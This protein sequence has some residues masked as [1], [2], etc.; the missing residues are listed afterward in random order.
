MLFLC[1]IRVFI[2]IFQ[3]HVFSQRKSTL[4]RG[5]VFCGLRFS[6][7]RFHLILLC[8]PSSVNSVKNTVGFVSVFVCFAT[9]TVDFV[10]ESV[11]FVFGWYVSYLVCFKNWSIN[12]LFIL[13]AAHRYGYWKEHWFKMTLIY[14]LCS[15]CVN[16]TWFA[17]IQ[18][19]HIV[20]QLIC[21]LII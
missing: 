17:K 11:D 18:S 10:K 7:V 15:A 9:V 20:V 21:N 8:T 19:I 16:K 5:F 4:I 3:R 6:R 1:I 13:S 12:V 2:I 14:N